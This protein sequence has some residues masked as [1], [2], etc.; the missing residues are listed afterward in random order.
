MPCAREDNEPAE[1]QQEDF[2]I[3]ISKLLQYSTD[4]S[5]EEGLK[6]F[7]EALSFLSE[8]KRDL[9]RQ[10]KERIDTIE[11]LK[12]RMY[13]NE[14][15][16]CKSEHIMSSLKM[17]VAQ[18]ASNRENAEKEL[19]SARDE[20]EKLRQCRVS[21][22][23]KIKIL[24]GEKSKVEQD[25]VKLFKTLEEK[26]DL[27]IRYAELE[28]AF[29]L[30]CWEKEK[31]KG[32]LER[33]RAEC[34]AQKQLL[35]VI[36]ALRHSLRRAGR[37]QKAAEGK[38]RN[39]ARDSYYL[40][41]ENTSLRNSLKEWREKTER[42]RAELASRNG[43]IFELK[44]VIQMVEGDLERSA[45]KREALEGELARLKKQRVTSKKQVSMFTQKVIE[46]HQAKSSLEKSLRDARQDKETILAPLEE[47]KKE[48]AAVRA[49]KEQL[50]K[51]CERATESAAETEK[52]LEAERD[53]AARLEKK[54]EEAG[55]DLMARTEELLLNESHTE[56]LR[57]ELARARSGNRRS[58]RLIG[59]LK[60]ELKKEKAAAAEIKK[61]KDYFEQRA[62]DLESAGGALRC[63]ERQASQ[64]LL[65]KMKAEVR[66]RFLASQL[67][68]AK[69]ENARLVV[70][71]EEKENLLK[72]RK[73]R[74]Q[75]LKA[76]FSTRQEKR[77][78]FIRT[79]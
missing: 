47:F 28:K 40:V 36:P 34:E 17:K 58:E 60:D 19:T 42:A 76:Q 43:E 27:E 54:L 56:N 25:P 73:K 62:K 20:L 77:E 29:K 75:E 71:L 78:N 7:K 45:E 11:D 35:G 32:E 72:A 57:N 51:A 4:N 79:V 1:I 16:K 64:I 50:R 52:L 53:K 9:E 70:Q 67:K 24:E 2:R 68:R 15:Q 74:L 65:K 26:K 6:L 41:E 31:V 44:R 61:W 46:L 14:K 69:E 66:I 55:K 48:L 30:A 8:K 5:S 13:K 59:S 39:L 18:L 63:K 3:P 49:E 22:E 12:N 33:A 21:L 37:K 38:I 23:E 10:L